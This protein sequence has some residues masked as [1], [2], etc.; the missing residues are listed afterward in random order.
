M[1]KIILVEKD[2]IRNSVG[3]NFLNQLDKKM[4]KYPITKKQIK[5]LGWKFMLEDN[6]VGDMEAFNQWSGK[7]DYKKYDIIFVDVFGA[8]TSIIDNVNEFNEFHTNLKNILNDKGFVVNNNAFVTKR[9]Y[10]NYMKIL[11]EKYSK[12]IEGFVKLGRYSNNHIA[13]C[14]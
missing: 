8:W 13:Y 6:T 10:E 12:V 3:D 11:N 1:V 7:F 9:N 4:Y 2:S 5:N 14:A